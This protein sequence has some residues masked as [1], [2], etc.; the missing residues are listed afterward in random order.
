M[1]HQEDLRLTYGSIVQL[2]DDEKKFKDTYFFI[3]HVS[4]S[5]IRLLSN[6]GLEPLEIYFDEEGRV[7]HMDTLKEIILIFQPK[8]G[9][10]LLHGY[11]PGTTLTLLMNDGSK[12]TG[13]ILQLNEDMIVIQDQED[14][15]LLNLDFHF[16]GI[17][18]QYQIKEIQIS[19]PGLKPREDNSIE[20][21]AEEE[22]EYL[23]VYSI[24]QQIDDY[25][26]KMYTNKTKRTVKQDIVK[27]L[28]LMMKYTDLEQGIRLKKLSNNLFL[29]SFYNLNSEFMYPVSSYVYRNIYDS[30]ETI[31]KNELDGDDVQDSPY[32]INMYEEDD[33]Q[34]ELMRI[35]EGASPS[36]QFVQNKT[37]LF[38]KQQQYHKRVAIKEDM[39]LLCIDHQN[40]FEDIHSVYVG[41]PRNM[42][43]TKKVVSHA[44]MIPYTI[45]FLMKKEKFVLNGTMIHS[46]KQIRQS[47]ESQLGSSILS[48]TIQNIYPKFDSF[49]K[50][51]IRIVT[52]TSKN[53]SHVPSSFFN[54]NGKVFYPLTKYHNSFKHY[55]QC[56]NVTFKDACMFLDIKQGFS[57]YELLREMTFMNVH[58]IREQD[59]QW[60][61]KEIQKST[62][63]YK[64][65]YQKRKKEL[66]TQ[67]QYIPYEFITQEH[68]FTL[69]CNHYKEY[70]FTTSY[71]SEILHQTMIDDGMLFI[72][73]L[74]QANQGLYINYDDYEIQ[75]HIQHFND[76][77]QEGNVR[78]LKQTQTKPIKTYDTLQQ[79]END[80]GKIILKDPPK[81][82]GQTNTQYLYSFL[83][84]QFNY[85]DSLEQFSEQLQ[86]ILTFYDTKLSLEENDKLRNDIFGH[87]KDPSR[88]SYILNGNQDKFT[89]FKS[90]TIFTNLLSK[91]IELQVRK[92]DKCIVTENNKT[93]EYSG[94]DWV[95]EGNKETKRKMLRVQNSTNDFEQMK[96]TIMNDS[97]LQMIA[98]IH[99][100]KSMNMEKQI[101]IEPTLLM[102]RKKLKSNVWMRQRM[103]Y[104]SIKLKW[105]EQF[106]QTQEERKQMGAVV[107]PYLFL[108]HEIMGYE[109][110]KKYELIQLFIS[111]L[112][113]KNKND[114]QWYYCILSNTKLVP[115]YFSRLCS[116]YLSIQ[117]K[118]Y[119]ETLKEICLKEGTISEQGDKW[120][121][122]ES[123]YV[124]QD[125][126]F[127]TNYGYD[128]NGF[129]IKHDAI[130]ENDEE[131]YEEG[132]VVESKSDE[133]NIEMKLES[134]LTQMETQFGH[135]VMSFTNIIG[136]NLP[137]NIYNTL[138]KEMFKIA[139]YEDMNT[140][141]K[142]TDK[143]YVYTILGFLLAF[144]QSHNVYI[145]KTFP[146]CHA[147]FEGY[148][149]DQNP[150]NND[151][152]SYL[153]CMLEK[154]AKHNLQFPYRGFQK[155][156]NKEIG[157]ELIH[158]MEEKVLQNYYV[159]TMLQEKRVV[160]L[161]EQSYDSQTPTY[162]SFIKNP[163]R[164]R[165]SLYPLQVIDAS[166]FDEDPFVTNKK[167][168]TYEHMMYQT[169]ILQFINKKIEELLRL[170][171]AKEKPIMTGYQFEEPFLINYC[172]NQ[173]DFIMNHVSKNKTN[174]ETLTQL[175]DVCKTSEFMVR[176]IN[177]LYVRHQSVNLTK[178]SI[179]KQ[180][181][182]DVKKIYD[183]S[184]V[185]RFIIHHGH[186]DDD[187]QISPFL[188]EVVRQK[189]EVFYNR[190]DELETKIEKL[191]DH[192]F[193]YDSATL[194]R[195][196]Y[197]KSLQQLKLNSQENESS[198]EQPQHEE[199]N[200][201]I[202]QDFYPHE[203]NINKD[204]MRSME[205]TTESSRNM[206]KKYILMNISSHK[207]L[208]NTVESILYTFDS[209]KN[210]QGINMFLQ[211]MVYI[212]LCVIPQI[213]LEHKLQH[214]HVT[215]KQWGFA[216]EH[217]KKIQY[218]YESQFKTFKNIQVNEE[219]KSL[220]QNISKM[221]ALL[222]KE[223]F[224]SNI[225]SQF[226][227]LKYLFYRGLEY[228]LL[229]DDFTMTASIKNIR[230]D[231][232]KA[233]IEFMNE[234]KSY[235]FVKY[236][237]V[238]KHMQK[239]KKSEKKV[240]TDKLKNMQ[241]RERK[242]EKEKMKLKLGDWSYGND[243]RVFKYYK[244]LYESEDARANEVKDMLHE[245][246]EHEGPNI[247]FQTTM[248]MGENYPQ[249][250]E[251]G[252]MFHQD[253]DDCYDEYGEEVLD[254]E[255]N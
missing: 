94:Q 136:M 225:S 28:Q 255:L 254:D 18:E 48:K 253:N 135:I 149:L 35:Y 245:I 177:D 238:Q 1:N 176:E 151:G 126:T 76:Q 233:I 186:F 178:S 247:A 83:V 110:H 174:Q 52:Q 127:D 170:I 57:I 113:D 169:H 115:R 81:Q 137:G 194:T 88:P 105:I 197:E 60:M 125:I 55:I 239:V 73:Y 193:Q 201:T 249:E 131:E 9:Y 248:D 234:R 56:M 229:G 185:Y 24:E 7:Q 157:E 17:D 102:E 216:S 166:H 78:K 62:R 22:E 71:P 59:F 203:W 250:E 164:F 162:Q 100:E 108:F 34:S 13:T 202:L 150:E 87:I 30:A 10:A 180:S 213:V 195:A 184:T 15:S 93:F 192:G 190:N 200:E 231:I 70:A 118:S 104:N 208:F 139:Y 189:P 92:G 160:L 226:V 77:L 85:T 40:D 3:D 158:F 86:N 168:N 43:R 44:R 63:A 53:T 227:Y 67:I 75:Q 37:H 154:L 80:R 165:P 221:K 97:L 61:R 11:T 82:L 243:K 242:L 68:L 119:E 74:K 214:Q 90:K 79:L 107:S 130:P 171:I 114:P 69:I 205:Q 230:N 38:Q 159:I 96:E 101:L 211:E 252:R 140:K 106:N 141:G 236:D 72:Y 45:D 198:S 98:S 220:I 41:R 39:P 26:N 182:E 116:S 4:P 99:N 172:C 240:K 210:K 183:I 228:Y 196:L 16:S 191:R 51:K 224:K 8:E 14:Q 84:S 25:V 241:R 112:C 222:Y 54:E 145:K 6:K 64:E 134:H 187:K 12:R 121:H 161:K 21:D 91:I 29:N 36:L 89:Q 129:K 23:D 218:N 199:L 181:I 209:E 111:L 163:Q 147:S 66:T 144:I 142:K 235:S 237:D 223:T 132:E 179:G 95:D 27:Y 122:K 143:I 152:V 120:I 173:T 219:V 156:N 148:P 188:R 206:Y 42:D 2:I 65:A 31:I 123:G 117:T 175:L 20:E 103:L 167:G 251:E 128:E 109:E 47:Q 32:S 50:K 204:N 212:L 33:I 232:N 215:C 155:M 133:P 58:E 207:D 19:D 217:I 244:N 246:Y 146:G 153:S 5:K 49:A 124:L 138:I 46:M